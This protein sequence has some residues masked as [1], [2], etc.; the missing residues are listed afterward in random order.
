MSKVKKLINQGLSRFGVVLKE[1]K[2]LPEHHLF[3]VREMGIRTILDIG[4][5]EG[6]FAQSIRTV[7][8]NAEII[9]FEPV[10]EAFARLQTASLGDACWHVENI[11]LGASNG[12]SMMNLH[13]NH[14]SSSSFLPSTEHEGSLY[15]ETTDQR[16][17]ELPMRT[18][19]QWAALRSSPLERPMMIKLDVQGFEESVLEGGDQ[20]FAT[21]EVVLIEVIVQPLYQGQASFDRLVFKLRE[22]GFGF[23]GVIE[24]GTDKNHRVVSLDALFFR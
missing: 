14:T 9:S 3:G 23:Q 12:L 19:N 20:V 21:A 13:F 24:H 16:V 11:A 1:V 18:L 7:F 15:P 22:L 5:N 17:I 10:P 6:Q 2:R 4:A 8:P